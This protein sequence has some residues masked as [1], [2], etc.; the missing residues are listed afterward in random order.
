MISKTLAFRALSLRTT[1]S[2]YFEYCFLIGYLTCVTTMT[3]PILSGKLVEIGAAIGEAVLAGERQ[4]R[5]AP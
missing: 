1:L 3:P 5:C 2:D 4:H